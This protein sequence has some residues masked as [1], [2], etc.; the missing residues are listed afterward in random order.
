MAAGGVTEGLAGKA[1]RADKQTWQRLGSAGIW[2]GLP[3]VGQKLGPGNRCLGQ[4]AQ[5]GARSRGCTT[6]AG[7]NECRQ[8]RTYDDC[9]LERLKPESSPKR[10]ESM[11]FGRNVM[12]FRN[13]MLYPPELRAQDTSFQGFLHKCRPA[14]YRLQ[15]MLQ[16]QGIFCALILWT[17]QPPRHCRA[18][19]AFLTPTKVLN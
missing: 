19:S 2:I 17:S 13:P 4:R 18:Q 6:T 3:R 9:R 8:I 12:A 15:P 5:W 1:A 7:K 14:E 16:P 10:P 11:V